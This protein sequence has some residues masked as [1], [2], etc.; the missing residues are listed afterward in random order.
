MPERFAGGGAPPLEGLR[1]GA[2]P[3]LALLL[4]RGAGGSSESSEK[5]KQGRTGGEAPDARPRARAVEAYRTPQ[6]LHACG[7]VG[8]E[9]GRG[10]YS[11]NSPEGGPSIE[12]AGG[13]AAVGA[14]LAAQ[15]GARPGWFVAA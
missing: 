3:S 7:R 12:G 5:Q 6:A 14:R 9:A 2:A 4:P 1:A 8:L 15:C 13:A 11:K 10:P